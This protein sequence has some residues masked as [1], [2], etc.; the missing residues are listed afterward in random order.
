[1]NTNVYTL[2]KRRAWYLNLFPIGD[3]SSEF[4]CGSHDNSIS[5]TSGIHEPPSAQKASVRNGPSRGV[6]GNT[7]S[8]SNYWYLYVPVN[9]R[10]GIIYDEESVANTKICFTV[11][12]RRQYAE[13]LWVS[14]RVQLS[15]ERYYFQL[16]SNVKNGTQRWLPKRR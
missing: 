14:R 10:P 13:K 5:R 16:K 9:C 2:R 4:V 7:P 11:A 6:H 12:T 15:K 3:N 1:M 8:D